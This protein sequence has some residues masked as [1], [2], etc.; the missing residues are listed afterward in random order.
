MTTDIQTRE[1]SMTRDELFRVN[2]YIY[3]RKRRWVLLGLGGLAAYVLAQGV[4]ET[5][6]MFAG[7]VLLFPTLILTYLWLTSR[8]R[9]NRAFFE[10]RR[11]R[12]NRAGLECHIQDRP[13]QPIPWN[14]VQR[15]FRASEYCLL[16]LDTRRFYFIPR[17]AFGDPETWERFLALVSQSVGRGRKA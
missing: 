17:R 11:F 10:R 2:L 15:V 12:F 8:S 13:G 6:L 5:S 3:W 14:R 4:H 7:L 16:F 1:F 9:A